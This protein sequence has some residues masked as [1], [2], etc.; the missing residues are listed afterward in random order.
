MNKMCTRSQWR[1]QIETYCSW[2]YQV[3]GRLYIATWCRQKMSKK[4]GRSGDGA[5]PVSSSV[6]PQRT[7]NEEEHSLRVLG[8]LPNSSSR[9]THSGNILE[10]F[11]LVCCY[12]CQ[13]QSSGGCCQ[14]RVPRGLWYRRGRRTEEVGTG[15]VGPARLSDKL[16]CLPRGRWE[17]VNKSLIR[18]IVFIPFSSCLNG[19]LQ[20]CT[21]FY[22]RGEREKEREEER[23]KETGRYLRVPLRK[24]ENKLK[25]TLH[26]SCSSVFQ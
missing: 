17:N 7:H 3:I 19:L 18:A 14:A 15:P 16:S 5:G 25:G 21:A 22:L 26:L 23:E 13:W 6:K 1:Q 11:C 4:L 10:Q 20:S 8:P 12:L 24:I 2:Q 9:G